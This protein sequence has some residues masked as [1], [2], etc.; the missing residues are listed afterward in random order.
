MD[1]GE[2][3]IQAIATAGA[4]AVAW[5]GLKG[6]LAA[7]QERAES[8]EKAATKAS[9]AAVAAAKS[10]NKTEQSINNR[11]TP[12]SDRWDAIHNDL[13]KVADSVRDIDTKVTEQGRDIQGLRAEHQ[14]TRKDIGLLHGEDRATRAETQE[15]RKDL[16][17]HV[18]ET[19]PM[20]PMLRDLHQ[21]YAQQRDQQD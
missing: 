6:K 11:S 18:R 7:L 4:V 21:R 14:A 8:A 12:A 1:W 5:L 16:Q 9:S 2:I 17:E 20:M 3:I 10:S 19:A 13:R 15:V